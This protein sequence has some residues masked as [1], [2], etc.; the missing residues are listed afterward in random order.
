VYVQDV[1]GKAVCLLCGDSVAVVKE[2]NIRARS[3]QTSLLKE[4]PLQNRL[5]KNSAL[6]SCFDLEL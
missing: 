1:N 3:Q 5:G 2:H 6:E 4:Q